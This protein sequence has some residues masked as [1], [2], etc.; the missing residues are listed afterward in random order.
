[1]KNGKLDRQKNPTFFISLFCLFDRYYPV[2][3]ISSNKRASWRN[4]YDKHKLL[5][6]CMKM[7]DMNYIQVSCTLAYKYEFMNKLNRSEKE[8]HCI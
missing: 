7:H 6:V 8:I 3:N 1:M 5:H 2:I 4:V